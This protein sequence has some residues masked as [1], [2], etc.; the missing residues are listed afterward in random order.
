M[1]NHISPPDVLRQAAEAYLST[2]K[3]Q[4]AA[5]RLLNISRT[6]FQQRLRQAEKQGFVKLKQDPWKKPFEIAPLP[7]DSPDAGELRDRIKKNFAKKKVAEEARRL[8]PIKIKMDGPIC[9]AHFGDPH[10]DDDGCDMA[11]LE[12]DVTTVN[13]TE[14]M[15]AANLGDSHNNWVG[16]LAR[17]YGEQATSAK[18]AWTLVEWLTKSMDWLYI[19]GGN[20]DLWSGAGDPLKWISRQQGTAYE[21]W[22]VRAALKFPNGREVRVNARHDFTGHSMWNPNHGPMKAAKMGWRDH[23]LTCGH[24]HVSFISG[25]DVD[26]AT[27]LLTWVLRCAG[28]K[29]L[30]RYAAELGLPDQSPF[31]AGA[32]II[33]PQYADDDPRLITVLPDLEMAAD[34]LKFLR[35]RNGRR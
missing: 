26:P 22:G 20:H 13:S 2:D 17:L 23:I 29:K 28:Y 11:R 30:D 27:K 24:K 10:V 19:I 33:D 25:P 21:A 9:I 31:A 34:F 12:R 8:I 7:S 5:A 1:A 4:K 14:G 15:F 18:D 6:T 35:R 16:R 3:N 32:T